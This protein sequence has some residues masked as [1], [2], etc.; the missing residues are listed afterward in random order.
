MFDDEHEMILNALVMG[1]SHL[2]PT[3]TNNSTI[4]ISSSSSIRTTNST[5]PN[6]R[7]SR[8]S[9]GLSTTTTRK[10]TSLTLKPKARLLRDQH[11]DSP[12]FLS[13]GDGLRRNRHQAPGHPTVPALIQ[14]DAHELAGD[15]V[16]D[17]DGPSK[18]NWSNG[19][20]VVVRRFERN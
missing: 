15:L 10:Q 14:P 3:T 18:R 11:L 6:T 8:L 5:P 16:A 2:H 19:K 12:V 4:T 13:D 17:G 1:A 7:T 20:V 9:K